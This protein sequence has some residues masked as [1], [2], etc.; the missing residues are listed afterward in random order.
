LKIAVLGTIVEDRIISIDGQITESFGGLF[1]SVETLRALCGEE[2]TIIPISYVGNDIYERVK[3]WFAGDKRVTLEGLYPIARPNNRVELRYTSAHERTEFSLNPFPPLSGQHIMPFA[4]ADVF[5]V[6][7]ISGW[8][9]EHKALQSFAQ[10]YHGILSMDIHSL[11]LGREPDGRRVLRKP[12]GLHEWLQIP[13]IIQCN[14]KEFELICS[15]ELITFYNKYCFDQNKIINLTLG[16]KGSLSV[17]REKNE[18]VKIEMPAAETKVV[19]PTGCGD[20]FLAAFA[21][22][23]G[24]TQN[25]INAAKKANLVAGIAGSKKG[26]PEYRWLQQMLEKSK[27]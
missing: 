17:Y 14:R 10:N 3:T 8:D 15:G 2:D 24:K 18:I 5:V 13:D 26:L 23:Y 12:E 22:E 1:Y 7:F 11:T 4:E 16:D 20:V 6:N 25:I 27:E 19:D 21:Y 9:V